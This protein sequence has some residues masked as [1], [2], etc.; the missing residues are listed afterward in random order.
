MMTLKSTAPRVVAA[1]AFG[2]VLFVA[3]QLIGAATSSGEQPNVAIARL[4]CNGSPE[5]VEVKNVGNQTQNFTGWKLLSDPVSSES[6]DLTPLM[7]LAPG[8]SVF[9]ESGPGA[10]GTFKWSD[11]QIFRDNDPTD[12]VRITDNGGAT[13][14]EVACA[15]AQVTPTPAATA[16]PTAA[17]TPARTAAAATRTPAPAVPNGG[18]PPGS[19]DELLSPIA[20]VSLGASLAGAGALALGATSL[21]ALR[22]GRTRA[23]RPGKGS[24]PLAENAG[25]LSEPGL[26]EGSLQLL[27][28]A[29]LFV[30]A[31]LLLAAAFLGNG[32]NRD[33]R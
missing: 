8:A 13:M 28:V 6:F 15:A 14:G 11:Q 12:F 1:L 19:S 22:L 26:S 10:M 29:S 5:V 18:G 7:M 17:P 21:R 3:V 23:K 24:K 20:L 33:S 2:A 30:I 32:N 9:I 16:A 31:G 27:L 25:G 4:D